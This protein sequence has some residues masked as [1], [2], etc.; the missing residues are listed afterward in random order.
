MPADSP[1][2]VPPRLL[3]LTVASGLL[4][5]PPPGVLVKEIVAFSQTHIGDGPVMIE[6]SAYTVTIAVLLQVFAPV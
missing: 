5:T 4:H 6:G 2:T 3:T 1:V